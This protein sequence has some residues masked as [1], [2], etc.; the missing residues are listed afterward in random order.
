VDRLDPLVA[1]SVDASSRSRRGDVVSNRSYLVHRD[2][3]EAFRLEVDRLAQ[4]YE[5]SGVEVRLTGPWP[6]YSFVG[7]EP[8]DRGAIGG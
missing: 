8:A 4:E 3:E 1:Q 6:P 7:I 5:P 2:R